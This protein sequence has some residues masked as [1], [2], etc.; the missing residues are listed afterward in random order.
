MIAA[1]FKKCCIV[2]SM[3]S[4]P[5]WSVEK[6][7]M[8]VSRFPTGQRVFTF[9]ERGEEVRATSETLEAVMDV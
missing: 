2:V 4:L 1:S 5:A 8:A 7:V 9:P 3:V 6:D